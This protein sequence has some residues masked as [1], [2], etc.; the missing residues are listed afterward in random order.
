MFSLS[1]PLTLLPC[2]CCTALCLLCFLFHFILIRN[3][4]TQRVFGLRIYELT[5][6]FIE[7]TADCCF[8]LQMMLNY[9]LLTVWL[10]DWHAFVSF[11]LS[12]CLSL[13][14]FPSTSLCLTVCLSLSLFLSLSLRYSLSL[15]LCLRLSVC[16]SVSLFLFHWSLKPCFVWCRNCHFKGLLLKIKFSFYTL[17]FIFMF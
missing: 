1:C 8:I 9:F 17:C 14:L 12:V 7:G 5:S 11:P 16:L 10:S 13:C 6:I 4:G 2:F 15:H 3:I